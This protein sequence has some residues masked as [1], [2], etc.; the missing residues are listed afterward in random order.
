MDGFD[1]TDHKGQLLADDRLRDQRL[2]E[3]LTLGGP[4]EALFSDLTVS[5]VDDT[6]DEPSK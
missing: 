3:D 5:E 6:N 4:S 1:A 2:A